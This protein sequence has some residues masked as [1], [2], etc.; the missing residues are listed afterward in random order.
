MRYFNRLLLLFTFVLAASSPL[1]AAPQTVFV[2][3][4]PQKTFLEEIAGDSL[5]IEVMV[6]PG[7][8]PATYEPKPSQMRKLAHSAA[9]FAIGVPFENAW[10]NKIAGVNPD[11]QIIHTEAGIEKTAMATHRHGNEGHDEDHHD[12]EAHHAHDDEHGNEA[13]EHHHDDGVPDPHIW[14]SP[15]LVKKQ[16]DNILAGLKSL[17]PDQAALFEANHRRFIDKIDDL[18]TRLQSVLSD[19]QGGEFMVFHPSWGY[20]A[21]RYGLEQIAIEVEG[22]SP[23][24]SQLQELI[25][26]ARERGI[27]I[28][29]AQQQ[30]ST[31]KARTIA[32]AIGG[33]VLLV[34]P[35]APDWFA[36]M[37][38][39]AIAL[40][41]A[42]Q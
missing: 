30:F 32:R 36:N 25:E 11:M 37:N 9:Y 31:K 7:A 19:V 3:I 1:M 35:L 24:P 23:K 10:L 6:Q 17:Y 41:K 38:R 15:V 26:H 28:I 33:E 18:D 40:S 27:K 5:A 21:R 34:D 12:H 42:V 14:L 2:S 4:L 16:A 8:S 20:F 13:E 22:K 39:I 29:F